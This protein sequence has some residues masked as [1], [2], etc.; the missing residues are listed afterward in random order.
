MTSLTHGAPA[1]ALLLALILLAS[2]A[3]FARPA[4]IDRCLLRPWAVLHERRLAGLLTSGFVHADLGHLIFNAISFWA[5]AF[6]L[7]RRIGSGRFVAL[8]LCGLLGSALATCWRHRDDP[9]Y[10]S[11][12]ASGAILA[13]LFASVLYFPFASIYL[14]L[15]PVPIPAPLF[16]LGYLAYTVYAARQGGSRV[17]HDAHLSGALIGLAFVLCTDA[18][19]AA[20]AVRAMVARWG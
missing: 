10:R 18:G 2:L 6:P 1:A 13:V 20:S 14:L 5:F 4:L 19:Q 16:A 17:N 15:L 7:E 9:R 3:G 8:Y 12:G 11:L